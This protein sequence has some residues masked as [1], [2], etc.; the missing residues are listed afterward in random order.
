VNELRFDKEIEEKD[1]EDEDN[2]KSMF[3][4]EKQG[5]MDAG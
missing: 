3:E 4:K 1:E 2:E 5:M